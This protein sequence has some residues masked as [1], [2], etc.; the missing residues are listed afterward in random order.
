[1]KRQSLK[2]VLPAFVF[3][4]AIV[5]SFAF[6]PAP[7]D[8]S[9][10]VYIQRA[11]PTNCE[12]QTMSL[13]YGCSINNWGAQCTTFESGVTRDLYSRAWGLL[14]MDPYRLPL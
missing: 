9:G 8:V 6:T 7:N 12:L 11:L 3:L 10:D 4:L 2:K 13:P 5:A 1:M 14:C